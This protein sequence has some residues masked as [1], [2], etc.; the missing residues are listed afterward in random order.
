MVCPRGEALARA[1][2]LAGK[3]NERAPNVLAS[4]KELLADAAG[5]PLTRQLAG[6]R[7]HFVKNLHHANAGI[8]IDA[9]LSKSKPDYE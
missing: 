7:D 8:G 6:E 1:L 5:N 9:F 4:V 2:A 3:L